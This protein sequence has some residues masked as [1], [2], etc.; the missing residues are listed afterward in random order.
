ML[1]PGILHKIFIKAGSI[2][3]AYWWSIA[4]RTR[5]QRLIKDQS[6]TCLMSDLPLVV[7]AA[8]LQSTSF[9]WRIIKV[10]WQRNLFFETELTK[11]TEYRE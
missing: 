2:I 1:A 5:Q 6:T 8:A 4:G 3:N 7:V 11:I 9:A 10:L